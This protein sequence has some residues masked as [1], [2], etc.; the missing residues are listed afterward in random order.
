MLSNKFILAA[1]ASTAVPSLAARS[2]PG[3]A[4]C[5][6]NL[7]PSASLEPTLLLNLTF[8]SDHGTEFIGQDNGDGTFNALGV[9]GTSGL[10]NDELKAL[11]TAWPGR[12]FPGFSVPSWEVNTAACA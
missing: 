9:A 6:W 7:T 8:P 11:V 4:S 3:L 2:G 12:S 5:K 1:I 10:D